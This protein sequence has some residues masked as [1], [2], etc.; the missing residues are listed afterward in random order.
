MG[1]AVAFMQILHM[2]KKNK[3]KNK[4]CLSG[5]RMNSLAIAVANL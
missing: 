1:V 2:Q 3:I 4:R 5:S